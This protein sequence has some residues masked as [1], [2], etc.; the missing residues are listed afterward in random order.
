MARHDMSP[1][2]ELTLSLRRKM[3][4]LWNYA[5]GHGKQRARQALWRVTHRIGINL[6]PRRL[7]SFPHLL[8]LFWFVVLMWGERW[9]FD[10]KVDKCDWDHWE[11]WVCSP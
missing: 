10:S 6:Q 7:L 1:A 2:E 3:Q 11:D 4:S 5:R 8:V 9:V